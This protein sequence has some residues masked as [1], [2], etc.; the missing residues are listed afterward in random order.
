VSPRAG[1]GYRSKPRPEAPCHRTV[2]R[3]R[4]CASGLG[5]RPL[6][7]DGGA[8]REGAA[9]G[10][11]PVAAP[12]LAAPG[13]QASLETVVTAPRDEWREAVLAAELSGADAVE[14][15]SRLGAASKVRKG[16]QGADLVLR[17]SSA[18]T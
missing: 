2:R 10:A 15:L 18:T 11:P 6:P 5:R 12:A 17:G 14:S 9:P 4:R 8:R 1:A 3:P 7:R 16:G 13:G